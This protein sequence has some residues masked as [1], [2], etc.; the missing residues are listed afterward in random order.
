LLTEHAAL[1]NAANGIAITDQTG[2]IIYVNPA[3]SQM[4]DYRSP[5]KMFGRALTE[6]F[7]EPAVAGQTISANL[8]TNETWLGELRARRRNGEE[9]SVQVSAAL[10]RNSNDELVGLVFSFLDVSDRLR[11]NT[12]QQEAE[13]Q[14]VMI[15][16]F[17]TAC[18]HLGQP[19]TVLMA[20]LE[21]LSK[22]AATLPAE[23]RKQLADAMQAADTIR[24]LLQKLNTA[25]LYRP[26]PYS[27]PAAEANPTD[28]HILEI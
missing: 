6:L 2:H 28:S 5:E 12:A 17:G 19:A 4:W 25:V 23:V 18:H 26:T 10:N 27:T 8:S 24:E 3:M 1:Q 21:M 9:F 11:A 7:A 20:N 13:R 14:R 16:S 15:E 22:E